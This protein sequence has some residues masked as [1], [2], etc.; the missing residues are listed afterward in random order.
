MR[1]KFQDFDLKM[2]DFYLRKSSKVNQRNLDLWMSK[3][4]LN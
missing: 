3:M 2:K 1:E 4:R